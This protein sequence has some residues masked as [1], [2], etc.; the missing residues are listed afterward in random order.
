[1]TQP[2]ILLISTD[3][4]R[5]DTIQAAGNRR[6][7]TPHLDWLCDSGVRFV[8]AY[9]DCPVCMPARTTIMNGRHAYSHRVLSN[10]W[11]PG[12]VTARDSLPG[13]L[14]AA[15]YQTRL[16]GKAHFGPDRHHLGFEHMELPEDHVR[17]LCQHPE[18]GSGGLHGMGGNEFA[19]AI[20]PLPL[21]LTQNAWLAERTLD[22]LDTRDPSRPFFLHVGFEH[23]HPPLTP[24]AGSFLPYQGK[25]M[26]PRIIGD[27]SSRFAEVPPGFTAVTQE[28]SMVQ[29][30]DDAQLAELRRFYYACI[31]E[32]DG[33]LGRI[34]GALSEQGRLADTWIIFT[35]DHGEMLGDHWLAGKCVPF[36]AAS[37]IPFIVRPPHAPRDSGH[38]WR[39]SANDATVCLA[40]LLPTCCAIAG[41]AAPAGIDGTAIQ[42][43]IPGLD[44]HTAPHTPRRTF[45]HSCMYLHAVR[46]ESW[47]LC[48]ETLGGA[49][50]LFNLADD[51]LEQ[52]NL[53]HEPA[54]CR[55]R[56]RLRGLLDGHLQRHDLLRAAASDPG[57]A[58]DVHR[59][60]RHTQP[61]L[62]SGRP[63]E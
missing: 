62:R 26:H 11:V 5:A 49:E 59:L 55:Q 27:W 18:A 3:Q 24:T 60:P 21:R 35:S 17:W 57:V 19:P 10:K 13:R 14:A 36:D 43:A 56:E 47:K 15:G 9:T 58:H 20:N 28:L 22:F 51:P 44:A 16:L 34:F 52:R 30:F 29:R 1:M 33:Q 42:G 40:D 4:Q 6:I 38:G 8:N 46:E 12:A 54:A 2:N 32:V 37:R 50:L 7:W 41:T 61:G 53:L 63:K 31:S 48:R 23:P 25:E 39:G 45:F